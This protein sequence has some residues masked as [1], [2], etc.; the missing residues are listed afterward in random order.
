MFNNLGKLRKHY[1]RIGE[2]KLRNFP[3]PIREQFKYL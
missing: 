2:E 1:L 3:R